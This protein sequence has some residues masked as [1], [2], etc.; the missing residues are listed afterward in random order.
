MF[1]ISGILSLANQG[2]I[3][4]FIAM[5]FVGPLATLPAAFAAT[6][7]TFNIWIVLFLSMLGNVVSNYAYFYI[8]VLGRETLIEKYGH[9][10]GLTKKRIKKIEYHLH[11]HAI[12]TILAIKLL[13]GTVPMLVIPGA[14]R[15]SFRR[16]TIIS[17]PIIIVESLALIIL[18][19]YSG[20]ALSTMIEY[21]KDA[22]LIFLGIFLIFLAV[23]GI[24]WMYEK[25]IR[26]QLGDF[27]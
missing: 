8:G 7:G 27:I 10:I 13:P 5:L 3:A 20:L 26:K 24:I 22:Q 18:G 6:F 16:F 4:L 25:F 2:Y 9:Y 17:V 21:V 12:K 1:D 11:N 23:L 14:M 19:Y 15:M